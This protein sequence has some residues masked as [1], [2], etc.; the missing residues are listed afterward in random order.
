MLS[1]FFTP[2]TASAEDKRSSETAVEP[3]D[4]RAGVDDRTLGTAE[5]EKTLFEKRMWVLD[6][7][8]QWYLQ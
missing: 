8:K 5:G 6:A 2:L 1:L 7:I 4:I 3:C